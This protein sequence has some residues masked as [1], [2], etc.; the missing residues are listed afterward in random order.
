[1]A[2]EDHAAAKRDHLKRC[3]KTYRDMSDAQA[4]ELIAIF[5]KMDAPAKSDSP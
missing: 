5:R 3:P 1:M 2:E 4:R